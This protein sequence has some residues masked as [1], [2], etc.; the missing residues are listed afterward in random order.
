MSKVNEF[1]TLTIL[2]YIQSS[3][4]GSTLEDI[5]GVFGYGGLLSQLALKEKLEPYVREK[6]LVKKNRGQIIT[7]IGQTLPLEHKIEELENKIKKEPDVKTELEILKVILKNNSANI[8]ELDNNCEKC[9][10][11]LIQIL[12]HLNQHKLIKKIILPNNQ[13]EYESVQKTA[14]RLEILQQKSI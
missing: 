2:E 1:I 3:P 7:Y 14:E 11:E 4:R 6:I 9:H 5:S 10:D 12:T 13:I 8:E